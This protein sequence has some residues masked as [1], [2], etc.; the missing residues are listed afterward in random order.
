M[1]LGL[2]A[3]GA[4]GRGGGGRCRRGLRRG[5]GN[6]GKHPVPTNLDSFPWEA[7]RLSA[8]LAPFPQDGGSP[9][10]QADPLAPTQTSAGPAGHLTKASLCY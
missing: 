8:G 9:R 3:G 7:S 4:G 5:S 10:Q 1:P 6:V 2:G